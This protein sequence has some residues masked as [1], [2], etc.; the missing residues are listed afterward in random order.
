MNAGKQLIDK[1]IIDKDISEALKV[2]INGDYF[3]EIIN[4]PI[5]KEIKLDLSDRVYSL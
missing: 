2:G 5:N 4:K 3:D 1:I